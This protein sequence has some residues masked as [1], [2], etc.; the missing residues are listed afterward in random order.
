MK[1]KLNAS[2]FPKPSSHPLR[3]PDRDGEERTGI[4]VNAARGP[5]KDG[6]NE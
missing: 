1:I 6:T 2:F 5:G 4:T 3:Q